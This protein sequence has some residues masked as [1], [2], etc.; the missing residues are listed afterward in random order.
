M[1][2]ISIQLEPDSEKLLDR[3]RSGTE[4]ESLY[5]ALDALFHRHAAL[6]AAHIT[7]TMLSGQRLSRRTGSLAR[8]VVGIGVRVGG[9]PGMRIG[10]LQGPALAYAGIHEHGGIIKP[11]KAKALAAPVGAALTPAGV[12]RYPGPRAYPGKLRFVPINRGNLIGKLVDEDDDD[13]EALFLLL[14]QVQV[15]PKHYLRDGM[16]RQVPL[17]SRDA[18]L[19]IR[20]RMLGLEA[21]SGN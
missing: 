5:R 19:L 8:S 9:V 10:I 15:A 7:K 17:A 3:I 18:S 20:N 1:T 4:R 13:N 6:G 11:K 12:P 21:G 16:L 2:T 14:R